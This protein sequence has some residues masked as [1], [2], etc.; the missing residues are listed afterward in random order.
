MAPR[1]P[2]RPPPPPRV[3]E[4]PALLDTPHGGPIASRSTPRRPDVA[5]LPTATIHERGHARL[6]HVLD[7]VG[8]VAK[9][10]PLS[11]LLDEAPRRIASILGADVASLYLLEGDGDQLVMRGNVGFPRHA[12]GTVRLDIGQGITWTAVEHLRP[13]S[14]VH[15]PEHER[16]R[17]FPELDE[18]RFPVFLAAPIVGNGRPLGAIVVQ[19]AGSTAFKQRDIELLAALTAPIAVAI[20]HAHLIDEFRDRRQRNA[21]GTRKVTLPGMPV[22]SGRALGAIAALR[23]PATSTLGTR[24][25]HSDRKLLRNAFDIAERALGDLFSR[26]TQQGLGKEASFLSTYMV[27]LADQRLKERA[28]ELVAS[29]HTVAQALNAVAREVARA[30]NG[31]V[32]DPFLQERAR[33]IEDLCDALVML[34]SPDA[35]AEL[36]SKAVLIGDQLTVFDLLISARAQPVGVALTE[37]AGARSRVLLKLLGIPSIVDVVG[38][39]RWASPGDVALLDAEHGFL[40]INPS[41]AEVASVRALRRKSRGTPSLPEED[42]PEEETETEGVYVVTPDDLA[43]S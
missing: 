38:G 23:R 28:F 43:G 4:A 15:A 35:R 1:A 20:R 41:R 32:G 19:R 17:G 39:F 2:S 29:G 26:A 36:P 37:R 33:D 42:S 30:A 14:V 9:P 24:P 21:G 34:A 3:A 25:E 31:M 10:I 5:H 40:V 22:V 7:F 18:D 11:L 12:R 13:I 27:M 6:D 8:F 16:Y